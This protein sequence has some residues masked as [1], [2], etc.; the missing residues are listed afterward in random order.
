MSITVPHERKDSCS[1]ES[2]S[3][4]SDE[5]DV[6]VLEAATNTVT[7]VQTVVPVYHKNFMGVDI[8]PEIPE[9]DEIEDENV[10]K[11][12]NIQKKEA[13]EDSLREY[14]RLSAKFEDFI[15]NENDDCNKMIKNF[16]RDFG[17][18]KKQTRFKR[19]NIKCGCSPYRKYLY[20]RRLNRIINCFC[21]IFIKPLWKAL[22]VIIFYPCL[23]TKVLATITPAI[24][25]VFLPY[26]TVV[27]KEEYSSQ[28]D[29]ADCTMLLSLIAFPWLCLL[30]F[31]PWLINSSKSILKI[32]FCLGLVTLG[33][34]TFRKSIIL[35]NVTHYNYKSTFYSYKHSSKL[36]CSSHC[37]S[38]IWDF[39]WRN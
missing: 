24:Y 38:T 8:L 6:K 25:V 32:I 9:E 35:S 16:E 37:L 23:I 36:R 39:V 30:V 17:T 33:I 29:L 20:R 15:S 13:M 19:F 12:E 7:A 27:N 4:D 18:G 22:R 5:I 11:L 1:S 21:G 10:E 3:D 14:G 26:A 31:L 28:T 34:S 2:S